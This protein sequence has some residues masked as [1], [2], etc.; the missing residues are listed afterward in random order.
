MR[1]RPARRY[2][3]GGAVAVLGAL[4]LGACSDSVD[5]PA[6]VEERWTDRA[7]VERPTT[8][9]VSFP[10]PEHCDWQD[11]TF[12]HVGRDDPERGEEYLRDPA[13]LLAH[14]VTGTYAEGVPLPSDA[15]DT[16]YRREGAALWVTGDA[17]YV[18]RGDQ[19]ERWP[20]ANRG[21]GCA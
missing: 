17:A 18:V 11:I 5:N 14:A 3:V 2:R 7:G 15:R 16:G 20:K 12:L 9:I 1:N 4:L 10:G 21:I 19:I 8:E 6:F 13:G